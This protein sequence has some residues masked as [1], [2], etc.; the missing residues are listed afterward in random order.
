MLR[1][2]F[3]PLVVILIVLTLA[4]CTANSLLLLDNEW[5]QTYRA[6]IQSV[7]DEDDYIATMSNYDMQ[8]ADLSARAA[9]ACDKAMDHDAPTAVGF[10]RIA[11]LSAWKS[12]E[13]AEETVPAIAA[14]GAQAC[15][16]LPKG[17]ASQPRDCSLFDIVVS[18]ARYDRKQREAATLLRNFSG[19]DSRLPRDE[20]ERAIVL[21]HELTDI[22]MAIGERREAMSQW[23][24]PQTFRSYVAENW[25]RVFCA[26]E[27]LLLVVGNT[28]GQSSAQ[29]RSVVEESKIMQL[30]LQTAHIPVNC[31]D[32]PSP[33]Q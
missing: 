9:V 5:A 13:I 7:K 29:T 18:F 22:F 28:Y 4:G 2:Q 25:K 24:L 3:N 31:V 30:A 17:I 26:T 23:A 15:A 12:G 14:K 19:L 10:Y 21:H 11:V 6:K 1:T 16:G 33:V 8:L 32:A 20:A 27:K